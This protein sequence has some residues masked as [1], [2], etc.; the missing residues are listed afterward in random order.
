LLYEGEK[1]NMEN[2]IEKLD[3]EIEAEF[4]NVLNSIY[5]GRYIELIKRC[6][7]EVAKLL[8]GYDESIDNAISE[9]DKAFV[10][11]FID[12]ESIYDL[13]KYKL[14]D[15]EKK[16]LVIILERLHDQIRNQLDMM[17]DNVDELK[18][19]ISRILHSNNN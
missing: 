8:E 7:K 16:F 11:I 5:S 9:L 15:N 1:L 13:E 12:L 6:D 18:S 14:S 3:R 2:E 4:G 19:V 10:H 17:I